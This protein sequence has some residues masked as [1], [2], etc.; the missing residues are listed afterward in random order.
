MMRGRMA[1]FSLILEY[2]SENTDWAN[3]PAF[4]ISG[5]NGQGDSTDQNVLLL[6]EQGAFGHCV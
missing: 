3:L 6:T 4:L 5:A 1:V 2:G